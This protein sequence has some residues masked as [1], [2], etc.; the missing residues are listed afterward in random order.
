[1]LVKRNTPMKPFGV[2][3]LSYK[4]HPVLYVQF[5]L[6]HCRNFFSFRSP[7]MPG[8]QKLTDSEIT[9]ITWAMYRQRRQHEEKDRS[10]NMEAADTQ[11]NTKH[12]LTGNAHNI[13]KRY[14]VHSDGDLANKGETIPTH[15]LSNHYST[16]DKQC[17]H[18]RYDSRQDWNQSRY[19]NRVYSGPYF[20]RTQEDAVPGSDT[21]H[22][23]D[24]LTYKYSGAF[25]TALSKSEG[26]YNRHTYHVRNNRMKS[27]PEHVESEV[28]LQRQPNEDNSVQFYNGTSA[29]YS[30]NNI[31]EPVYL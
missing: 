25:Q 10:T 6:S 30:Q 20:I 1:M 9:S 16:P 13:L 11:H 28:Q 31:S 23:G 24:S 8:V 15:P 2:E 21:S 14:S 22:Y 17:F 12:A 3:S 26:T 4:N 5:I 19:R 29:Y 7:R 27:V 18:R